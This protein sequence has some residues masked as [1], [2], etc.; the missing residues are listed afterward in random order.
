[1]LVMS[2]VELLEACIVG[3]DHR[4]T[5][6]NAPLSHAVNYD[7]QTWRYQDYGGRHFGECQLLAAQAGASM[8]TPS[9]LGQ[10]AVDRYWVHP[11]LA[12][13]AY[14]SVEPSGYDFY[15]T[16]GCASVQRCL[17]GFVDN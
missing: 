13:S 4:S 5:L 10:V 1:M 11:Q 12:N 3:R 2:R 8:I 6:R 16:S 9:T 14:T 7:G 15:L 17:V